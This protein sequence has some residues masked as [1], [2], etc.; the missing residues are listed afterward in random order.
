MPNDPCSIWLRLPIDLS[1]ASGPM[2]CNQGIIVIIAI[3]ST[4]FP[5]YNYGAQFWDEEVDRN[6]KQILQ[7]DLTLSST[8]KLES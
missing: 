7:V 1:L 5:D 2:W 8:D 4:P 6:I 3:R